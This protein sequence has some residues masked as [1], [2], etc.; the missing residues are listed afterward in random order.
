MTGYIEVCGRSR[1]ETHNG[2][3]LVT[4]DCG[5][6]RGAGWFS[7]ATEIY[8]IDKATALKLAQDIIDAVSV[9]WPEQG[10]EGGEE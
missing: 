7:P 8:L 9:A 10:D 2:K 4:I 6:A 3:G 5:S 1:E